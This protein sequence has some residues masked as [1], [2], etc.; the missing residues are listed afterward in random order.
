MVKCAPSLRPKLND[1]DKEIVQ[2]IIAANQV[3]GHTSQP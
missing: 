2:H 3:Q 1:V